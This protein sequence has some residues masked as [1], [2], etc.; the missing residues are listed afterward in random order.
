VAIEEEAQLHQ[1]QVVASMKLQYSEVGVA[2]AM[3]ATALQAE[4]I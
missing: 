2:A 3:A 4:A 1:L